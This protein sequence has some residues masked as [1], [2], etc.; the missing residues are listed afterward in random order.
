VI[1]SRPSHALAP[2]FAV[3]FTALVEQD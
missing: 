1:P 2:L 3:T